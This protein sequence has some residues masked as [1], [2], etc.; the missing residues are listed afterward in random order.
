MRLA[1]GMQDA[2]SAWEDGCRMLGVPGQMDAGC[3][4]CLG[5]R[6]QDARGAWADAGQVGATKDRILTHTHLSQPPD[7]VKGLEHSLEGEAKAGNQQM[8]NLQAFSF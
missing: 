3:L 8:N 4:G 1:G 6:M 7:I 2:R 5:R